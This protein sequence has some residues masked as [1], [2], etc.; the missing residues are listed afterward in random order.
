[1]SMFTSMIE[2][3]R[4]NESALPVTTARYLVEVVMNEEIP[5]ADAAMQIKAFED[6]FQR[7]LDDNYFVDIRYD[8]LRFRVL[9]RTVLDVAPAGNPDPPETSEI[10]TVD[11]CERL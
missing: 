4:Q 9:D 11:T 2:R 5:S 10:L 6:E 7:A 8:A 1:M 3:T